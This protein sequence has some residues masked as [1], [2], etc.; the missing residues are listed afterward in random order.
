MQGYPKHLNSKQDYLNMLEID[1]PE[2][3]KR[4]QSLLDNRF[5]W[6]Q[7]EELMA[8]ENGIEDDTHKI[9]VFEYNTTSGFI[10]YQRYQYE[11]KE[12]KY[13]HLFLLGFN[14]EEVKTLLK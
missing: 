14:V 8:N 6:I 3:I 5:T 12:D 1:K 13:S 9:M 10:T 7:G 4:L 11:L 2:T